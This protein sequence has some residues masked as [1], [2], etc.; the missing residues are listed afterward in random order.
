MCLEMEREELAKKLMVLV[1]DHEDV[2]S[3]EEAQAFV[4][5]ATAVDPFW[6]WNESCRKEL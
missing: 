3:E 6:D 2:L 1:V 5:L 4:S